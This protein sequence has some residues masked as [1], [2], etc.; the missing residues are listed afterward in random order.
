MAADRVLRF[1]KVCSSLLGCAIDSLLRLGKIFL[2]LPDS[3][4]VHFGLLNGLYSLWLGHLKQKD[5]DH[6]FTSV[7]W[8]S[9]EVLCFCS[10]E[11]ISFS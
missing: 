8:V 2:K 3:G 4:L 5:L 11:L 7:F 10:S 1:V 6:M 9:K